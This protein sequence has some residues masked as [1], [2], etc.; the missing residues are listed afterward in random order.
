MTT[1]Y[2]NISLPA[3]A[4]LLF[5][6]NLGVKAGVFGDARWIGPSGNSLPLY[7]DCLSV[8]KIDF[9]L[10]LPPQAKASFSYGCNDPRLMDRSLNI[11][12]ME[13]PADSSGIIFTFDSDGHI[14]I[15]RQ[16]YHPDDDPH[17]PLASF[18]AGVLRDGLS[19]ISITSN[20]GHTD[21]WVNGEKIGYAG[22]NPVGNGGDF[23]AFPVVG[24]MKADIQEGSGVEIRN[25]TLSNFRSPSNAVWSAPGDISRTMLISAEERSMP[26]LKTTFLIPAGKTIVGA[27]L[28]ATARGIYDVSLNGTRITDDYFN[29]GSSQ[30]NKTHFYQSFDIMSGLKPGK[31]TIEVQLAEGWW[32][33]PSTFVGENWNFFGDRPSFISNLVI[34]Y[35]DGSTQYVATS[36]DTWECSSDGPVVAGSFFNGEVYD[37]GRVQTLARSWKPAVEIAVDSTACRHI[38]DW[39][40]IAYLPADDNRVRAVDTLTAVSVTCPRPGLWVYDMGQNM[41]AVPNIEFSNL[42]EGQEISV[43]YAEVLYPD[44]PQYA[45]NEGMIMTENLRAA[46]CRDIYRARGGYGEVFSPRFTYHGFRYVEISGLDSPLPV[47]AVKAVAVSSIKGFTANY[48]CSDSLVNRLWNNIRWSTLSNFISIPTDC[49]QRNERL[50]WMGD[51]SVFAPTATKLADISGLLRQYLTSVRD[52]QD[53]DG[54]YPDVAPTGFGF[55]GLLWGS[56]GITVPW[57]CWQRYADIGLLRTHYPSMKRYVGY[58][59][60][61]AMDPATGIIMQNR[62]WGDLADWLSPEYDKTDKSL[63]WECYFIYDLRIMREVAEILGMKD[64]ASYFGAL[65]DER[66][67]FF[68]DTYVD[69]SS[70]KTVFSMFDPS[71][72]GSLVD[73][74]VSYALPIAMGI[75]DDPRFVDNFLNTVSRENQADDGTI[76]PP[77]SLMTGFIGTAWIQ[78]ALS[79][80]GHAEMAYRLLTSRDYPSWLYPVTQGATSVWERLNSYTHGN[81]FGEN[82]RMNSFNHY[83]FGSVGNWLLTRSLGINVDNAGRIVIAPEPDSGGRITFARGW[84]DAPSGRVSSSWRVSGNE[85]EFEIGVPEGGDAVFI[86]GGE[87]RPLHAGVNKFCLSVD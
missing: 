67:R 71:R 8:F 54:R 76:C 83:S 84:I 68:A 78:E 29:P 5:M 31:N 12:N 37:A 57:E 24:D 42:R 85:V 60:R 14:D 20:L 15:F 64:D 77:Y 11:F 22:L 28:Y 79:K 23:L 1:R 45:G 73:T 46:M 87:S 50:G 52:C 74:Q 38:G 18:E 4:V 59:L 48:E 36:P 25:L 21:V 13:N 82:N 9:D 66:L 16:G 86:Y 35:S 33:G 61:D 81:G 39:D 19:H 17:R 34:D 80:T 26:A 7:T 69:K 63:I 58:I 44:L 75:Y 47:E 51:I 56:A 30:Y 43:R 2:L 40:N 6:S 41:A 55:G 65:H 70:G 62:A 10:Y 3:I 49:P 53:D 72:A 27:K 32:C